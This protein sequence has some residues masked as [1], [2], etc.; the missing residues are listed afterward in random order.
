MMNPSDMMQ[1]PF[2]GRKEYF[3]V[4][5][6]DMI[7]CVKVPILK[8]LREIIDENDEVLNISKI[9]DMD[10]KNLLRFSLLSRFRNPIIELIRS[11]H[12]VEEDED[13]NFVASDVPMDLAVDYCH[14]LYE[15][16]LESDEFIYENAVEGRIYS[17]VKLLIEQNFTAHIYFYTEEYDIRIHTS[18][19][20]LMKGE[21]DNYSYVYGDLFDAIPKLPDRPTFYFLSDA[22]DVTNILSMDESVYQYTEI[23]LASHGYNY[24][25]NGLTG[26]LE[27]RL[28]TENYDFEEMIIKFGIITPYVF[29]DTY[30]TSNDYANMV[31][32][33]MSDLLDEALEEND[34]E[35]ISTILQAMDETSKKLGQLK[36]LG[37][38]PSKT[39]TMDDTVIHPGLRPDEDMHKPTPDERYI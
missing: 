4:D 37:Y 14:A 20:H 11:E 16:L 34:S 33:V 39:V 32:E 13:G 1:N 7:A 25:I 10:D 17:V 31:V 38:D 36:E 6:H 12:W 28:L 29:D 15:Q 2:V 24:F 18:I 8:A 35:K 22:D 21:S 30:Y 26:E 23:N 5:Y 3:F 9:S 27:L 19:D